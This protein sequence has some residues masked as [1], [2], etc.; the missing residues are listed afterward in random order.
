[1]GMFDYLTVNGYV[2]TGIPSKAAKF[3]SEGPFQTKSLYRYMETYE[4]R[5]DGCLYRREED[6]D[7]VFWVKIIKTIDIEFY[8]LIGGYWLSFIAKYKRGDLVKIILNEFETIEKRQERMRKILN[9]V[10]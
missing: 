7:G 6:D 3:F 1:M 9:Q 2:I 4:I 10:N 5:E 8:N